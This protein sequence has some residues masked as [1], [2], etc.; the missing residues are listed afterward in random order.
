MYAV[1]QNDATAPSGLDPTKCSE[2]SSAI[3]QYDY[4]HAVSLGFAVGSVK[5]DGNF[6]LLVMDVARTVVESSGEEAVTWGYGYRL[7]VE[8]ESANLATSLTLPAIAASVELGQMRAT[9]RL[10][11][12]GYT[13]ADLWKVLPV[14][15]PLDVDTHR[16]FLDA[17]AKVQ[18]AFA[19]HPEHAALVKL[20]AASKASIAFGGVSEV[21]TREA[22]AL[23]LM[24][25]LAADG[26]DEQ[27]VVDAVASQS[28]V[29]GAVIEQ[30]A[31][32]LFVHLGSGDPKSRAEAASAL[33][34]PMRNVLAR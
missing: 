6:R 7:L 22:V 14:P 12:K 23:A 18:Q 26:A 17:A 28:D 11:V 33:I 16:D 15:R 9:L 32:G 24:L 29:D 1:A 2:W 13:G 19:E 10:E 4:R 3:Y 30:L 27:R 21:E 20:S 31:K 8:V 25:A 5:L 34:A